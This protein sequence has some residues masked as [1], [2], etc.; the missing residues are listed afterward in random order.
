MITES[1][2]GTRCKRAPASDFTSYRE[3]VGG[4]SWAKKK[5]VGKFLYLE[6]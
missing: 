4:Y 6:Y 2:K 3:T 5:K 1:E